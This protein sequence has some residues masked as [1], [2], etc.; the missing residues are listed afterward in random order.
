MAKSKPQITT[1]VGE[2]V[3]Q[4]EHSSIAGGITNL[5]SH[6]VNQYGGS[7]EN[8]KHIYS[9]A[10]LKSPFNINSVIFTQFYINN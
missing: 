4:E 10:F 2:E 3:E 6:S 1:H 7:S 8:W 9:Y 5:Y